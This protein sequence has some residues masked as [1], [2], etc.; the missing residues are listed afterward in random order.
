MYYTRTISTLNPS[1]FIHIEKT[2]DSGDDRPT[3]RLIQITKQPIDPC[4]WPW[5]FPNCRQQQQQQ[6]HEQ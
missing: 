5:H 2:A 4:R 1:N 6:Q 3:A